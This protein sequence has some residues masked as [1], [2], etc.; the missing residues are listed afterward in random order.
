VH[1]EHPPDSFDFR[2]VETDRLEN[3]VI[4]NQCGEPKQFYLPEQDR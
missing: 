1:G 3:T 2:G 4:D